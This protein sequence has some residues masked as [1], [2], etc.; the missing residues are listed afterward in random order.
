QDKGVAGPWPARKARRTPLDCSKTSSSAF[1]GALLPSGQPFNASTTHS[2]SSDVGAPAGCESERKIRL[3]RRLPP[4]RSEART[5]RRSPDTNP[6]HPGQ[7]TPKGC[8]LVQS[9]VV[10]RHLSGVGPGLSGVRVT[11]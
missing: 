5:P 10:L 4:S 1:A 3:V 11:C 7:L 9:G 6:G 2:P 8:E